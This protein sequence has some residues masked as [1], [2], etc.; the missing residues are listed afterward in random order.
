M[1]TKIEWRERAVCQGRDTDLFYSTDEAHP[2]KK[3]SREELEA[4]A[5]CERCPVSGN[6]LEWAIV[7]GEKGVWGGTTWRERKLLKRPGIRRSCV[8]CGSKAMAMLDDEF[9]VCTFC[10]LS[11]LV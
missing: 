5:V 7:K 6:C 8:R 1:A 4:L 9:Q 3:R 2:P 10:G 11:K